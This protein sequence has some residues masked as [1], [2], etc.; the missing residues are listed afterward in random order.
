MPLEET[1]PNVTQALGDSEP[2]HASQQPH[3]VDQ[4][5]QQSGKFG[6][7]VGQGQGVHIGDVYQADPETIKRIVREELRLPQREYSDPVSLGLHALTEL[8]QHSEAR[9]AVITFRVDFQAACDQI[10]IIANYKELHDLLHT[11]EF[12]CYSG[13]VQE[14]KRFPDDE[15]TLDILTDHEFT[16]QRI[17]REVQEVAQRET[18]ATN[19][20]LWL[21]D[22]ERAQVELHVAIDEL[23]T[24][25]LQ[26]TIW[27]LNRVLAIQPSRINTNLNSAA[28]TLRLPALVNAMSSI[29]ESL[30]KSNLNQEKI[31]QFQVGVEVLAELNERL[32]AL[33]IGHDY[34][35]ELDLELRRIE[36]NLEKDLIELEMSWADLKERTN[37]L[38]NPA[39]DQWTIYFQQDSHNLDM[40]LDVQ[41]PI[42]VKRYF[43]MYRRR[44]SDRFYQV[45]ATLLRLCGE[46][47]EVGEPLTSVLRMIE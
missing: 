8:M 13:I 26:R 29:W 17:L 16:L 20:V 7:N 9:S 28:R 21:K 2:V 32:A 14:A 36:A 19:E 6:V 10:N 35:Q 40:A 39:G 3:S 1:T 22:L 46:L 43:R 12:Q 4:S 34:W 33:V 5:V 45:D 41:N 25:R 37:I 15:T 31:K 38:F 27:L 11:L 23:D 24:R 30:A 44:A 47:R 18:I 42:K